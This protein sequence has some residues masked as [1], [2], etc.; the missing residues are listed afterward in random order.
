M[1]ETTRIINIRHSEEKSHLQMYSEHALFQEGSWLSRP[2][3]SVLALLPHFRAL[4]SVHVLDLGCGVGRTGQ[5]L[6]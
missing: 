5:F 3:K 6:I 4:Q 2:V 1:D